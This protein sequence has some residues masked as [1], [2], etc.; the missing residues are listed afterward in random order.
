MKHTG[1][2]VLLA[3]RIWVVCHLRPGEIF[4]CC[5][6]KIAGSVGI[7]SYQLRQHIV[8]PETAKDVHFRLLQGGRRCA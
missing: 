2:T 7:L 6:V 3:A 8:R 1:V 4:G 5:V